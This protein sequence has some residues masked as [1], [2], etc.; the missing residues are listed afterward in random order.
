MKNK[1]LIYTYL[2]ESHTL[3]TENGELHIIN[4]TQHI[5]IN[6]DTFIHD[7]PS[8]VYMCKNEY[9]KTNKELFKRIKNALK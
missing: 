5:V 1:E 4:D 8:I 6:I 2:H 3:Y 9:K 7:L